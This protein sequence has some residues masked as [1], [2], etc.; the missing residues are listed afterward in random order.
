M[1]QC[2]ENGSFK[3]TQCHAGRGECWCV[4]EAGQELED[5]RRPM[6]GR[7]GEE[8]TPPMPAASSEED[9]REDESREHN[10]KEDDSNEDEDESRKDGPAPMCR[11]CYIPH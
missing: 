11:T 4:D 2:T 1:P 5:S 9:S 3:P 6:K 8:D 10:S 7:S